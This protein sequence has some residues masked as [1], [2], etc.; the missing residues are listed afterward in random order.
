V[1]VN[2]VV[3][4]VPGPSTT[5]EGVLKAAGLHPSGGKLFSAVSHKLLDKDYGRPTILLD[6]VAAPL[7]APVRADAAVVAVDG[8]DTVEPVAEK[9]METP[10]GGLPAVEN[11]IWYPGLPAV[12]EVTVGEV[13]GEEVSRRRLAQ[14]QPPRRELAP[15][16]ALTFDDG[17]D[18]N[19]TL[20][21][22]QLLHDEGVTATFCSIGLWAQ[23]RPDIVRAERDQG[24]AICD[25]TMHHVEHLDTKSHAQVDQEVGEGYRA[26]TGILGT[27]P[28]LFRA[29]GGNVGP[30]VINVAHGYGL[31]VLGWAIDPHDFQRPPVDV[32]VDRIMSKL[33]PGS[34][35]LL[36]DGG[37]DRGNT[38][39]AVKI[40]IDRLK[41]MGWGFATPVSPPGPPPPSPPPPP[42]TPPSG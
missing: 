37:G 31:R 4:Q 38:L 8:A 23:R 1:T 25:H 35:I 40:V 5:V 21:L 27:P 11:T 33:R 26:L 34:V 42:A 9:R 16:V 22:L 29:P 41:A 14:P 3:R 15:V 24:H 20:P 19:W 6:G 12:D 30:D 10:T 39:A 28:V 17:P 18:P 7:A 2:G 36:H 13:S 32:L